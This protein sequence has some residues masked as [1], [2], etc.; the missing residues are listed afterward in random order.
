MK[1]FANI[2]KEWEK[3]NSYIDKDLNNNRKASSN[4]VK[5]RTQKELKIDLHGMTVK[6]AIIH[7][8]EKILKAKTTTEIKAYI[9]HGAGN[10]SNGE[11]VLKK[12]VLKWLEE[13]RY[14]FNLYRSG[15]TNEGGHGVTIAYI[16][17]K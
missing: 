14:I 6:E 13:N 11:C 9:I 2:L 16:K 7:L 5:K 8:K 15:K 17:P 3:N 12:S 10:H 4:R 1:D